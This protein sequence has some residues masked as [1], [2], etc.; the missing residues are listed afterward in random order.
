MSRRNLR[1]ETEALAPRIL[2][3]GKRATGVEYWQNGDVR[4]RAGAARC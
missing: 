3:E 2:F 4:T 1:V